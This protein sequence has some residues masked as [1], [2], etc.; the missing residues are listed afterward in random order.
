MKLGQPAED[1]KVAKSE[2]MV[3]YGYE[4][5]IKVSPISIKAIRKR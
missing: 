3:I 4:D 2:Y 1:A 5:K